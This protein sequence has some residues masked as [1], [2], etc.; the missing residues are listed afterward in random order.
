M[1]DLRNVSLKYDNNTTALQNINLS[2]DS[3]EFVFIVGSSGAGKSSIIKLLLREKIAT[4]GIVSVNGTNV[5]RLKQGQIPLYRRKLG[6][7]F[8]S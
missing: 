1:I 4:T 8:S 5:G 2:I 3:G 6:V 7:V